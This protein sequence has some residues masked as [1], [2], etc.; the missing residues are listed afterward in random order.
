MKRA[1][2]SLKED[3]KEVIKGKVRKFVKKGYISPPE[4]KVKSLIKYFAVPIGV[5]K[6]VVQDW[7]VVRRGQQAE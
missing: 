7:H 2:P 3:E 5:L 4:G 1:Q 6:G